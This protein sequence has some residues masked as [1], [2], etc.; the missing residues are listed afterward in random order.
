MIHKTLKGYLITSYAT[1]A[2]KFPTAQ[3]KKKNIDTLR[4]FHLHYGIIL[5][6]LVISDAIKETHLTSNPQ[7]RQ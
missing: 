2:Y 4:L 6:N 5:K 3:K 7:Q 1:H